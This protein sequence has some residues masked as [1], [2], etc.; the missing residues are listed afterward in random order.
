[1][2][3]RFL[4]TN[5]DGSPIFGDPVL[6]LQLKALTLNAMAPA[7]AY[8]QWSEESFRPIEAAF[9]RLFRG[10]GWQKGS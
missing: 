4:G 9:D 7:D 6:L 2:A 10:L 8:R 3:R 5:Y 1:M